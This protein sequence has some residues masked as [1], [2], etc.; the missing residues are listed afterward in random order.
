MTLFSREL[1]LESGKIP[2]AALFLKR[3]SPG[4]RKLSPECNLQKTNFLSLGWE[5]EMIFFSPH[6]K[7]LV[8]ASPNGAL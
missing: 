4:G 3:M 7:L 2:R 8:S 5:W 6:N 1:D